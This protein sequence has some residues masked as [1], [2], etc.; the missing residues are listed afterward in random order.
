MPCKT[1]RT[2]I[3]HFTSSPQLQKRKPQGHGQRQATHQGRQHPKEA[4]HSRVSFLLT[5]F[6][7]SR[8]ISCFTPSLFSP[9]LIC[10]LKKSLGPK[11]CLSTSPLTPPLEAEDATPE[12]RINHQL[13]CHVRHLEHDLRDITARFQAERER[14]MVLEALVGGKTSI[15]ILTPCLCSDLCL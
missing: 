7:L 13:R 3:H 6:L 15:F 14:R 11:R 5:C 4:H 10:F 8:V 9:A 12:Q 2:L 1:T